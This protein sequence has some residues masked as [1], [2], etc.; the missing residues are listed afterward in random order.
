M[1]RWGRRLGARL[2]VAVVLPSP[3]RRDFRPLDHR[4]RPTRVLANAATN[5][6][7]R[8]AEVESSRPDWFVYAGSVDENIACPVSL[9]TR[10][11]MTTLRGSWMI[12]VLA[13]V[14]P[15]SW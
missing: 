7:C 12:A 10:C 2:V 14:L 3:K 9:Q 1:E 5:R 4:V 8:F 6:A 13:V 11:L 15:A